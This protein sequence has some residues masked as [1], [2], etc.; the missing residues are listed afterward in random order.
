MT[1]AGS[2]SSGARAG[3]SGDPSVNPVSRPFV[4]PSDANEGEDVTRAPR[5]EPFS[6][7]AARARDF[8][9]SLEEWLRLKPPSNLLFQR[10][11]HL[12]VYFESQRSKPCM[13]TNE[14]MQRL[15]AVVAKGFTTGTRRHGSTGTPPRMDDLFNTI[16]RMRVQLDTVQARND[17][18]HNELR[19]LRREVFNMRDSRGTSGGYNSR[20]FYENRDQLEESYEA[21]RANRF[22]YRAGGYSGPSG[23][24]YGR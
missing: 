4:G 3:D 14:I 16:S 6:D 22:Q 5:D 11:E 12:E 23:R 17:S 20:G 7:T 24:D 19:D 18:L 9:V 10:F 2:S 1:E 21:D 8:N 15:N 13:S